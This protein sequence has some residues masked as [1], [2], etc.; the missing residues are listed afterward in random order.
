[1]HLLLIALCAFSQNP[2]THRE[3]LL[4]GVVAFERSGTPGQLAV[5]GENAFV[6]VSSGGNGSEL[7][8][9]AA[10][11]F[12]KGRVF[13]IAHSGYYGFSSDDTQAGLLMNNAREWLSNNGDAEVRRFDKLN[14][15]NQVQADALRQWV[16]EG[17]GLL[18]AECP[19]GWAQVSGKNMRTEMPANWLLAPMGLV[20]ADGYAAATHNGNFSIEQSHPDAADAG[21]AARRLVASRKQMDATGMFALSAAVAAVAADDVLL[22]PLLRDFFETHNK[23]GPLK[24]NPVKKS[25]VRDR[26]WISLYTSFWKELAPA[27][28]SAAPGADEFPGVVA[29]GGKRI[30][31]QYSNDGTLPGWNS[32]G[33]YLNAGEV[34]TVK[35]IGGSADHWRVRVGCHKDTLWKL[36]EWRR[37]PEITHEVALSFG[38]N[39][40]LKIAT[41]W[42]GSVYLIP[43]GK[44]APIALTIAGV[45]AQPIFFAADELS[46]SNWQAL[47]KSKAPWAE[48]V[49][50][51]MVLSIPTASIK[52]LK[53][54]RAVTDYWDELLASHCDLA[55]IEMLARPERFV[56]DQQISAGY[57]HSGY[58]VMTWLDVVTP[59]N[60]RPAP[61]IDLKLLRKDGN[62]GY[63]HELGHNRQRGWWTFGG[64]GE[65]TNN[66]FSLHGGEV[67][68]D[69]TP[70]ENPWLQNQKAGAAK[71][72]KAGADWATWK[73]KPGIALMSFA[74]L[75]REF[76]WQPFQTFFAE[77][78][79]VP[80][81]QRPKNDQQEI[82]GWVVRM[83][84][85]L[86]LD[87][88]DYFKHWGWPI[89]EGV[90]NN[91]ELD[92]LKSW[93]AD[94]SWSQ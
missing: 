85:I 62:W 65:V 41:P 64:T 69:V 45:V 92:Q 56:G 35:L 80:N 16:A 47:R 27:D 83:S 30:T 93:Q 84:L 73:K 31:A 57:M 37:W 11:T 89:S 19:W 2:E 53:D 55:G 79:K 29:K 42:G 40:E 50:R 94:F 1:M 5:F 52:D 77:Y 34:M 7:P 8:L 90:R 59:S 51:N 20:F 18:L 63:F 33:Y 68:A 49:G 15:R 10:A 81:A 12:G 82:D 28:V 39:Q 17:G 66:L 70:W 38:D 87:L 43:S 21:A 46:D 13:A 22:L 71:Y 25:D 60:G 9:A 4:E 75:Q 14:I 6:V 48:L 23:R 44:A 61:L 3:Q 86:K 58:P 24:R 32:S 78:E 54:P 72:L 76:G 67:M 88:R 91:A 36:D 74:M 26:L